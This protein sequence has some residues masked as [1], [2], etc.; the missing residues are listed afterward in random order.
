M[1]IVLVIMVWECGYD[2]A[3]IV[4]YGGVF[5]DGWLKYL[6]CAFMRLV[7]KTFALVFVLVLVRDVASPIAGYLQQ[8]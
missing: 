7:F 2:H 5:L 4:V 3:P 8:V 6:V 1:N